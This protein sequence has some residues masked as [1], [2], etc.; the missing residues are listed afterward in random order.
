MVLGTSLSLYYVLMTIFLQKDS[1][2]EK[3]EQ[4]DNYHKFIFRP[5]LHYVDLLSYIT[6]QS[7][8]YF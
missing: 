4:G 1:L 7:Y 8:N 3:V 6:D 2:I 5:I